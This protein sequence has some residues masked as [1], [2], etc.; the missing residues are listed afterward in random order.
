MRNVQAHAPRSLR[1]VMLSRGYFPTV[2]GAE[3]QITAVSEELARRGVEVHVLTRRYAG[4]K[5]LET[6]GRVTV[7]RLPVPR[8]E[9]MASL[10]FTL[11]A[12]PLIRRIRPDVLHAHELL[13]PTTTAVVAQGLYGVPVVTTV[14][15]GGEIDCLE[16][17][18][19]GETRIDIFRSHVERFVAIDADINRQLAQLGVPSQL[20]ALI[21][22]GV[23][24]D[25]FFALNAGQKARLKT[26][27]QL[28]EGPN[29]VFAGRLVPSKRVDRL[30]DA[31]GSVRKHFPMA[32]LLIIGSGPEEDALRQVAYSTRP[33]SAG[34]PRDCG[35]GIHFFREI[36]NIAPYLQ[37]ADVFVSPSNC[38]GL[39]LALLEA[40]ACGLPVIA[41]DVGGNREVVHHRETGW[42]VPGGDE[43][44]A[45]RLAEALR[46]LLN[47]DPLRARLAGAGRN[48]VERSYS[49]ASVVDHLH[50]LYLALTVGFLRPSS[51][52]QPRTRE[53][54]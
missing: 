39:S 10:G 14:H 29:V 1:V 23:D 45:D 7:H 12:L 51:K 31:W 21:P 22:N 30:I 36:R 20:L 5:P 35:A 25:R 53:K 33:A 2:G 3:R 11:N 54:V 28:P 52:G 34:W 6:I 49:L 38:K 24:T 27:L 8:P 19:L 16:Q 26:A 4:L 46:I 47:D 41:T 37:A 43:R 32:R 18:W 42:L 15:G 13:S 50:E 48:L 9:T 17:E 44:L 40:M